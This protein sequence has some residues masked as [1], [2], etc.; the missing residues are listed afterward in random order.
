MKKTVFILLL[1]LFF[2]SSCAHAE[3]T[4]KRKATV[5]TFG[6]ASFLT[7]YDDFA[8]PQRLSAYDDIWSEIKALMAETDELL[9]TSI[10]TSEIARFNRLK[11]GESMPISPLTAE[12]F[13]LALDM[14]R[15]TNGY[16]NPAVFPLVDLWGFSPRFLGNISA[17]AQPYDRALKNGMRS[18]PDKAYITAFLQLADLSGIQ[19]DGDAAHG[20]ML[21]KV[22]PS[23]WVNGEEY[24]A[25]IDLG[26]IAKGYVVDRIAAILREAGY[27]SGY[28]SCGSSSIGFLKNT[29][30][31]ALEI[32]DSAFT[33]AIRS[34]RKTDSGADSFASL[35]VK[36]IMLSSS[37]DYENNYVVNGQ[38][39]CH[40]ID[41]FTGYPLNYSANAVQKGIC[42][43]TLLSG[44]AVEDD[45]L[46]TS[47]CL[48]GP[49]KALDYFNTHL[50]DHRIVMTL[51][52]TDR[53]TYE[54]LTNLTSDE[55]HF[56]DSAYSLACTVDES[57][58]LVYTGDFFR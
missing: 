37:G 56:T 39:C 29:S 20:Y 17:P 51:Y 28:F 16:F 5:G 10:E 22:T 49:A 55:I 50:K 25:Q 47:L 53:N 42:T 52:R 58:N 8:K 7:L 33:L 4:S 31:S 38:L 41:P 9:S 6:T 44:S 11:S 40:I 24:Q 12:V 26:G 3:I 23:V 46:T 57:G 1:S 14:N 43:I 35:R 54:V 34:P 27:T 45:A 13:Q 2:A 30:A 15:K 36:D 48:M 32:G 21:T 19:L 18:A